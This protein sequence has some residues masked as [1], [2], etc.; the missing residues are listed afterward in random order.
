MKNSFSARREEPPKVSQKGFTKMKIRDRIGFSSRN[1][2]IPG[3]T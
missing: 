3:E 2:K 1:L